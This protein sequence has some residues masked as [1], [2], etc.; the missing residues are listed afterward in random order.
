MPPPA[1]MTRMR[2]VDLPG[3]TQKHTDA[4]QGDEQRCAAIGDEGQGYALRRHQREHHADVE[5]CLD[6]DSGGDA[7]SEKAGKDV[8]RKARGPQSPKSKSHEEGDDDQ[9][10]NQ[11]KLLGNVGKD[12][13]RMRLG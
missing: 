9:G 6:K 12:E 5:E 11:T 2:S 1:I 7:E 13:V 3:E 8:F 10:A 4:G